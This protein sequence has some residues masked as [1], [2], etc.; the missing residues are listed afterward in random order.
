MA[1]KECC[2]KEENLGP[3]EATGA[4]QETMRRCKVCNC[5]HF[6]LSLEPGQYVAK[7]S[8]LGGRDA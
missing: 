8:Q 5:R 7:M 3:P 2:Q 6:R 1:I 4:P